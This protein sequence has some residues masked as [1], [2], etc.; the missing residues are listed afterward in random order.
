MCI[1]YMHWPG[2]TYSQPVYVKSLIRSQVLIDCANYRFKPRHVLYTHT[3]YTWSMLGVAQMFSLI[4][5][6]F[7]L[8]LPSEREMAGNTAAQIQLIMT[9]LWEVFGIVCNVWYVAWG[10]VGLRSLLSI[11]ALALGGLQLT[12]KPVEQCRYP[13]HPARNQQ[14]AL[15]PWLFAQHIFHL[16]WT[17]TF[18]ELSLHCRAKLVEVF[19][20]WVKMALPSFTLSVSASV[21]IC[22]HNCDSTSDRTW[23]PVTLIHKWNCWSNCRIA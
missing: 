23:H 9:A 21:V 13:H 7:Y 11:K 20:F 14:L 4:S 17:A 3:P 10:E 6:L 5:R 1:F 19:L 15:P 22:W 2:C 12:L 16:G 8:L 18:Q